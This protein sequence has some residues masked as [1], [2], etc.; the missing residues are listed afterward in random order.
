MAIYYN[1]QKIAGTSTNRTL[2]LGA[3]Y[4]SEF[5]EAKRNP[6]ALPGW[7]GEYFANGKDLYPD[8]YNAIKETPYLQCTKK[9]Y[10]AAIE[11]TGSC[12]RYVIDEVEGSL[13]LPKLA[14]YIKLADDVLGV[15]E[16]VSALPD[17][18]HNIIGNGNYNGTT[19]MAFGN[20]VDNPATLTNVIGNASETNPIYKDIDTVEVNH[21]TLY[22]WICAFN[23]AVDASVAQ[24]SEFIGALS[25]K[26]NQDLTNIPTNCDYVISTTVDNNT[27]SWTRVYKS[28]WCEQ[29]GLFAITAINTPLTITL[30]KKF[31]NTNY[32]INLTSVEMENTSYADMYVS[33]SKKEVSSFIVSTRYYN[34]SSIANRYVS[35]EAKGI[36]DLEEYA[37]MSGKY[38]ILEDGTIDSVSIPVATE[39][40][41][42][43]IKTTYQS[44]TKTLNIINKEN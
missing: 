37:S 44:D 20:G 21:T 4:Y 19:N 9:E 11:A 36:L 28:G 3:V 1:G 5:K 14:H 30:N 41:Y 15:T 42:G 6:G 2:P 8:L 34:N 12:S 13:R 18:S 39:T 40:N 32:S 17:H 38:G 25:G 33:L 27:N 16:G 29:G 10:D 7:T 23:S 24:A 35:W 43:T 31:K 22:P 26:A